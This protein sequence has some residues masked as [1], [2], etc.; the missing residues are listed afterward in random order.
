VSLYRA[1]TSGTDVDEW[2]LLDR[3]GDT[4]A[5]CLAAVAFLAERAT[6]LWFHPV[7]LPLV[8]DE[9]LSQLQAVSNEAPDAVLVPWH[10][11]HRGHPVVTPVSP[12]RG[13]SPTDHSGAMKTLIEDHDVNVLRVPLQDPGTH[14]DFDQPEDLVE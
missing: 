12:W 1:E 3:G 8:M 9:T 4:A 2:V 7:D 11:T 13:L 5:S 10:G 6:H 14:K